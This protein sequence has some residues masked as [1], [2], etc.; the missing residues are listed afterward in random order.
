MLSS[1]PRQED[2]RG[3]V[4]TKIICI[5]PFYE[6]SFYKSVLI[7]KVNELAAA[8]MCQNIEIDQKN[9]IF[10]CL[11]S[12]NEVFPCSQ[13]KDGEKWWSGHTRLTLD[14]GSPWWFWQDQNLQNME[15]N[16][17]TSKPTF[18]SENM[19]HRQVAS[20]WRA[21]LDCRCIKPSLHLYHSAACVSGWGPGQN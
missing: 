10:H 16:L 12:G 17:G 19:L 20:Y 2:F 18:P 7:N 3:Q 9:V 15:P 4:E 5:K 21:A 11:H 14:W 1:R 8:V 13:S 6:L